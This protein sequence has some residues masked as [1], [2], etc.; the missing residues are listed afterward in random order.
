MDF[1]VNG[2]GWIAVVL[3]VAA[4]IAGVRWRRKN[5]HYTL[6]F[7]SLALAS[8]HLWFSMGTMGARVTAIYA[9]GL[10]AATIALLLLALQTVVGWRL[11]RP[12]KL[13]TL[14]RATHI[15]IVVMLV[16]TIVYH[17][18]ANGSS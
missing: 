9:N 10:D 11:Q 8:I 13:R 17:V 15:G 2:S 5:I 16:A 1:V 14:L 4:G 6:G 12:G 3:I 18:I 7:A